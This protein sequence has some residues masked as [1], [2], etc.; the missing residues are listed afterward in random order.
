MAMLAGIQLN[1]FT[2]LKDG[3]LAGAGIAAAIDVKCVKL[4]PLLYALVSSLFRMIA[5]ATRRRPT[6][7]WCE[8]CGDPRITWAV[9]RNFTLIYDKPF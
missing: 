5:L 8:G 6:P 1:L 7:A 3:P 9:G 4:M 2:L